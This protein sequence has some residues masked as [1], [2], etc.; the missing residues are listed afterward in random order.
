MSL[1]E[2]E[3][4][5]Y[6]EAK[7][8]LSKI[9]K[10]TGRLTNRERQEKEKAQ[11]IIADIEAKI[12]TSRRDFIKIGLSV[13]LGAGAAGLIGYQSCKPK[14]KTSPRTQSA[15]NNDSNKNTI[16]ADIGVDEYET[17]KQNYKKIDETYKD[18]QEG[19]FEQMLEHQAHWKN[20]SQEALQLFVDNPTVVKL[21]KFMDQNAVYSVAQGPKK[22]LRVAKTDKEDLQKKLNDPLS[23]EIVFM[24]EKYAPQ[25]RAPIVIDPSGKTIRIAANFKV[26][27]WL[28]IMLAHELSHVYDVLVNKE[29]V[30]NKEEWNAGEV[31]AHLLEADLIKKWNPKT[32]QILLEKGT[33][34]LKAEQFRKLIKLIENLYPVTQ[35][36]A[37]YHEASLGLAGCITAVALE[38]AKSQGLTEKDMGM[39]YKNLMKKISRKF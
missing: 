34:L 13:V 36:N 3:Q 24:P 8:A 33:P 9:E 19:N 39:V 35:E 16:I 26:Q 20:I 14:E 38:H 31:R 6:T 28:G 25:M 2:Q 22:T 21:L 11:K 7:N 1:S 27:E 23:F 15:G 17:P 5:Q 18:T 29:N 10:K 12:S 37:S 30:F 4:T 32:Y